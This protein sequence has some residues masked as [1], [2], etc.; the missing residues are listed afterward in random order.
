VDALT[1][2]YTAQVRYRLINVNV[3]EAIKQNDVVGILCLLVLAF[4][5]VFSW[6]IIIFK[7]LQIV[8]INHQSADFLDK[9]MSQNMTL[10]EAYRATGDYA[11]TPLAQILRES[12]LEAEVENWYQEYGEMPL[13][14][15]LTL[16]K[17]DL[18][19]VMEQ[20]VSHEIKNLEKSLNFL[21]TTASVSPF[22]GLFGTVWGILGCFQSVAYEGNVALSA[23]AP[24]ISTALM[25]T[26]AGLIAA[27]PAAVSYN[28]FTSRVN[29]LTAQMDSFSMETMNIIQKKIIQQERYG[30]LKERKTAIS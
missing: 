1:L 23:L 17:V 28:Y 9:C 10:D 27:I 6:A 30:E 18:D 25:T 14:D 7:W 24:G 2:F 20:T 8:Y 16:A 12:Y 22:I 3:L 29:T 26:V 4:F 5:S 15:K 19:R 21:A 13:Q 11:D